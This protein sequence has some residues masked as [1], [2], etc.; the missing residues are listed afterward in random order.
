MSFVPLLAAR[1][2]AQ[3]RSGRNMTDELDRLWSHYPDLAPQQRGA[4]QDACYGSL[5]Q[6]GILEAALKE[7]LHK[8]LRDDA[9]HALLLVALYQLA[10]TRTK[11]YA[12]VDEAVKAA[13]EL[14][15][16]GSKGLV[17]AVLRNFQRQQ[18]ALLER[19]E[20]SDARW[21]HPD[22]WVKAMRR[23][24]PRDWEALIQAGNSH[25]PMTLRVNARKGDADL[26][27]QRLADADI[28]ASKLDTHAIVLERAVPVSKLPGFND[29]EVSVQDWGAQAAAKLL[30]AHSGMRVLD[31][32]AAPG[33]KT[34]H[35]LELADLELVALDSDAA[36]LSRVG[37]NLARL[38]SA[39]ALLCG[40]AGRPAAWWDGKPFD[41]ILADVPCSAT[42]VA[43]RHP[44]IKWLRR[45]DDFARFAAQQS[46]ILDALW[47][48]LAPGGKLLYAT[49]SIFPTENSQQAARF[50][51]RHPDAR[52]LPLALT[53]PN[54]AGQLLPN[55]RHDGFFYALF[56]K[57]PG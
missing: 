46:Q 35:L 52:A 31:A 11:P 40:D 12:V 3:V 23:A 48:L 41:R 55:E 16:D 42:G 20:A 29:G 9:L 50:A 2:V 30:D 22:W 45:P 54:E 13:R 27:L 49:C 17:N 6:L 24:W 36:R 28:P 19:I 21:S 51:E 38:G 43:R 7:L 10:Y 4:I 14:A 34:G 5:R 47:A 39:A 37:D 25:P 18:P 57:S 33:G 1:V 26:Y 56:E 53:Q 32:C 8:P 15:G 44:D